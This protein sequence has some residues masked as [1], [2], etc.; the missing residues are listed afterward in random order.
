MR[1]G[2]PLRVGRMPAATTSGRTLRRFRAMSLR[3]LRSGDLRAFGVCADALRR[4]HRPSLRELERLRK[5]S[6]VDVRGPALSGAQRSR[7]VVRHDSVSLGPQL[8]GRCMPRPG[9]HPR[10][11]RA[12]P[13]LLLQLHPLH[14]WHLRTRARPRGTTLRGR[15]RG[16]FGLLTGELRGTGSPGCGSGLRLRLRLR[17]RL[18]QPRCERI[19]LGRLVQHS[20][21]R[22]LRDLR[23]VAEAKRLRVRC[24]T[25]SSSSKRHI[26]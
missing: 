13:R 1:R 24:A 14:G 12:L 21:L 10:P 7:R 18:L 20:Q 25:R 16:G 19:L 2:Q 22:P 6:R 3:Q 23:G 17:Y 26:R 4:Q 11:R 9:L 8:R 15:V 5:S